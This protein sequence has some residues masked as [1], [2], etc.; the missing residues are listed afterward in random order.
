MNTSAGRTVDSSPSTY[1]WVVLLVLTLIYAFN[2]LDRQILT[3]LAEPIKN[4]LNL[5]DT[6]LGLL[7]GFMFA[8][9]YTTFGIPIAWLADRTHRVRLIAVACATWSIFCASCGL[10]TGFVTLALSR[11]GVGVGEAG[12]APPSY[13]LISDYFPPHRRALA[14]GLFSFGVPLG[15][16]AGAA[17]GGYVAATFGWRWAFPAVAAPGL[18]LAVVLLLVVR[19]RTRGVLDA[20]PDPAL[21]EAARLSLLES[22]VGF[23][24]NRTL[25]LTALAAGVSGFVGYGILNWLPAFLMRDKGMT[26]GDISAW[27]SL[28]SGVSLALGLGVGGYLADQW[29]KKNP[30]AYALL[31]AWAFLL[32]VPLFAAALFAPNWAL[33]LVLV[34]IPNGLCIVYLAPVLAIV[35]NNAPASTRSVSSALL[36]FVLNL[37]GIGGGPLFVGFLSDHLVVHFGNDALQYAML[38]LCPF[39]VL[40]AGC[41]YLVSLSLKSKP[42]SSVGSA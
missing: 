23:F 20:K 5:S 18:I 31:P 28:A 39:M 42:V 2:F 3:I 22:I 11:I 9:F 37:V 29:G 4:D 10:A 35:Q 26:L 24:R 41:H 19:E 21:P 27:Y 7:S 15:T 34:M 12:G 13:S 33:A 36:L 1:S 16:T 6:Q 38:A 14:L 30:R 8:I 17:F 25:A 40:A 32:G